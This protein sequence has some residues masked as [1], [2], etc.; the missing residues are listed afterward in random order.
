MTE[1]TSGEYTEEV[2]ADYG[3]NT[4]TPGFYKNAKSI[5]GNEFLKILW[6]NAFNGINGDDVVD[7]ITKVLE[8]LELIKIPNVDP[9]QLRLYVFPLSL[10]GDAR[11]WWIDEIKGGD[12]EVLIDDVVASDDEWKEFD[13]TN[14]PKPQL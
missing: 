3:S 14:Q 8:I 13:N 5:L 2:R 4:T 12:K 10:T 7:H 6:D 9:N 11:K 1:P